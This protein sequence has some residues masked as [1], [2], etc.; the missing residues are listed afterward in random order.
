VPYGMEYSG[1]LRQIICWFYSEVLAY[2]MFVIHM[3][4]YTKVYAVMRY[5]GANGTVNVRRLA[6]YIRYS[7]STAKPRLFVGT[8]RGCCDPV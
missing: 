3:R 8:W 1:L 4:C 6:Q 2:A 5:G 7:G